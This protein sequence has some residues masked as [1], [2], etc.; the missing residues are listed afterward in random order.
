MWIEDGA[1]VRRLRGLP[2]EAR[3]GPGL[4]REQQ[5]LPIVNFSTEAEKVMIRANAAHVRSLILVGAIGVVAALAGCAAAPGSS[6]ATEAE[7]AISAQ[8]DSAISQVKDLPGWS[9]AA[10]AAP[11]PAALGGKYLSGSFQGDAAQLLSVLARS[12][13]MRFQVTGPNPR[14]PLFVFV[15]AQGMTFED[16]LRD[17]DKQFG[18][19]ANVVLGN[20]LIEIRYR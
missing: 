13:G 7:K 1:T 11:Q 5:P 9:V 19:R 18:Q 12:R 3:R 8:I 6:G 14:L 2:V 17:V 20:D 10:D 4:G 16:L 15:D